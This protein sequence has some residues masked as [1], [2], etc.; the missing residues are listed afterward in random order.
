MRV[1]TQLMKKLATGYA[2]LFICVCLLLG[3]PASAAKLT[4]LDRYVARP[5]TNYS[6]RLVNTLPGKGHTT[7][8]L[9]MKS[10]AWLTTNEVHQ[11]VWQHWLTIIKPE[12][13]DVTTGLLFI[14]GG[15]LDRPAPKAPDGNLL[16]LALATRSVVAEL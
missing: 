11:P 2:A 8:I 9:E 14:G 1:P 15:S 5:D 12:I 10:Q 4:A 6:Y 13:V 3:V 7:F 16:R